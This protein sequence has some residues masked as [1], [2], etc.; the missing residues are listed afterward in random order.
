MNIALLGTPGVG[1]SHIS[2]N[3]SLHFNLNYFNLNSL[4]YYASLYR[5]YDRKRKVKIVNVKLSKKRLHSFLNM[6]EN[7]VV[8]SHI[9]E[10]PIDSFDAIF[11]VRRNPFI[12]IKILFK[13]FKDY[14]KV[15]E[16]LESEMIGAISSNLREKYKNKVPIYDVQ[17]LRS[18]KSF[19]Q[20]PSSYKV[21]HKNG[22]DWIGLI[23]KK[24]LVSKYIDLVINL[25]Q[26]A[27][28]HH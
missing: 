18:I 25:K 21:S 1:K 16:N 9:D 13:K 24:G 4:F 23:S 12:L 3:L 6:L 27:K 22:V 19:L 2:I 10:I 14:D 11:V 7:S 5:G 26:K 8:E 28:N 20:S 15:I 17:S